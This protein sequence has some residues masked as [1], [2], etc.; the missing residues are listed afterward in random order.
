MEKSLQY[1][2]TEIR[3]ASDFSDAILKTRKRWSNAFTF[4]KEKD[5]QLKVLYLANSE[6]KV[7]IGEKRTPFKLFYL[8]CCPLQ[9]IMPP[10]KM[11]IQATGILH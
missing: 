3:M 10:K 11:K 2:S 7:R 6:S 1:G 8:P 4:L 5:F 9:N